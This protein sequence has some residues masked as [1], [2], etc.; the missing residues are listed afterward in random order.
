MIIKIFFSELL[1]TIDARSS[2]L[3]CRPTFQGISITVLCLPKVFIPSS[4]SS[5]Y[6]PFCRN[7]FCPPEIASSVFFHIVLS[8]DHLTIGPQ[9]TTSCRSTGAFHFIPSRA[10]L[11]HISAYL[12]RIKSFHI[13]ENN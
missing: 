9:V 5:T 12:A 11:R 1:H 3:F 7:V 4:T 6:Y 10:I 2:I 13:L 8:L